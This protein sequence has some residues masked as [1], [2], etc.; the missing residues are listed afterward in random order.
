MPTLTGLLVAGII[1]APLSTIAL[2]T[3]ARQPRRVAGA[4]PALRRL[5]SALAGTAVL[6]G[7]VGAALLL[8]GVRPP[9]CQGGRRT[10]RGEPVVAARDQTVERP[11]PRGVG[12]HRV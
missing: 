12:R 9:S 4:W 1:A 11:R 10:R 2:F 6:A 7:I 5:T 8:L 3:P